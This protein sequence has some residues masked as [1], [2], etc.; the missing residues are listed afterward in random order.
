[1]T[2]N[3]GTV[4]ELLGGKHTR[5][6]ALDALE[7]SAVPIEAAVALA[8]A[9]SLVELQAL[10]SSTVGRDEFNRISLLMH[11]LF[12]EGCA[13][14]VELWVAAYADGRYADLVNAEDNVIAEAVLRKDPA[15]ITIED[16]RCIAYATS[17]WIVSGTGGMTRTVG[18]A[19]LTCKQWL[20]IWKQKPL[21][22][23]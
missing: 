21:V 7:A 20:N 2:I 6:A 13:D 19:G 5:S 15:E 10:P 9:K 23:A 3:A 12:D 17:E 14:P 1:M 11:R 18:P 16:A 4:A 8:A 22:S